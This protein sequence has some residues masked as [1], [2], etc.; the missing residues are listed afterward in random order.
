MKT[1]IKEVENTF[2]KDNYIQHNEDG[3]WMVATGSDGEPLLIDAVEEKKES[4]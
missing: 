1:T 3:T 4:N 2:G